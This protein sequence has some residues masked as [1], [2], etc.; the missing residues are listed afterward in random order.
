MHNMLYTVVCKLLGIL[1]FEC[2][3]LLN[4]AFSLIAKGH[5]AILST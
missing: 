1:Y 4:A 2:T 3:L 5:L